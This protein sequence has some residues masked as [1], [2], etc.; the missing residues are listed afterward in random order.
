MSDQPK[1]SHAQVLKSSS[2]IGASSIIDIGFRV[3]RAKAI[4]LL[5]GPAGIGLFGLFGSISEMTRSIAGMGLN[6]SGVR[7]IAEAVGSGN[8]QRISRTVKTL[9]RAAL[10]SGA[11][12]ALL[13][14]I[15]SKPVGRLTFGDDR[16]TGEVALLA[17]V[18]LMADVSAGQAA[19]IQGVRRIVDLAK[20]NVLAAFY[21]TLFGIP[22]I[23]FF[24]EPGL[25]PSLVCV[26][27]MGILTSWWYARKVK[28]QL[29]P[30]TLRD[31]LHESS[32][33]LKLGV[34]FMA[35]SLMTIG[36]G[37][38]VRIVIARRLG[39]E[40]AG[41]FQ[42]AWALSGVYASFIISSMEAEF[43]PRLTAVANNSSEC[44]RL[45]NEQAEVGLLLGGPGLLAT[46]VFAPFVIEL[47]YSAK[48]GPSVE[49]FRWICLGML[50][51]IASFPMC[52]IVMA[53]G[54]GKV[55][56]WCELALG[57]LFV[58][59]IAVGVDVLGLKGS[60]IGFFAAYV[61]YWVGMC[62]LVHRLTGFHW[63]A[64][65][66]QW[67]LYF[68][69]VFSIVFVGWYVLPPILEASSGL[70]ALLLASVYSVRT[71]G[72]LIPV[73]K[74]P[75]P[76]KRLLRLFGLAPKAAKAGK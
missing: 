16:H 6:K 8:V 58:S 7:Q 40:N 41:Y 15:C 25:V 1:K 14:L 48:F 60:G 44:N 12:G 9:R 59:F 34:V 5:L 50:L 3:A 76:A 49:I 53:K 66:R 38:L 21:G 52:I 62:L 70:V 54:L 11:L 45:V 31:I 42:A 35:S 65:N 51:R 4:A 69:P 67:A 28:V 13:L 39:V 37:Y 30:M 68:G 18:V 61:V 55:Y 33:L 46:L 19:L 29:V 57:L 20:M 10:W 75:R 36:S 22:I 74:F 32:T 71:L 2:L 73:E 63:S 47:F 64:A 56:F 23:Y 43:Y 26:A 17:L 27:A 24:G 72:A